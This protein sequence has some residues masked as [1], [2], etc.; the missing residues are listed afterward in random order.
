MSEYDNMTKEEMIETIESKQSR[1]EDLEDAFE[2]A[3]DMNEL[4]RTTG[5][6]EIKELEAEK[7]KLSELLRDIVDRDGNV[8]ALV[9][10]SRVILHEVGDKEAQK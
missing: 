8:P 10:R 7:E 3:K 1:I 9:G 2:L 5:T 4:L 6:R